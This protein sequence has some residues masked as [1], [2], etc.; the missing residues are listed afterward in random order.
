MYRSSGSAKRSELVATT[1]A[2][3][4]RGRGSTDGRPHVKIGASRCGVARTTGSVMKRVLSLLLA[5]VTMTALVVVGGA[6]PAAASPPANGYY[7][8][9][10]DKSGRCLDQDYSGGTQHRDVLAWTC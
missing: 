10:N 4:A 9:V 5:A 8:L 7:M 1:F 6:D 3:T 2:C